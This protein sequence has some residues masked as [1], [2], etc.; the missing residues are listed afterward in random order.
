MR[1]LRPKETEQKVGLC[2]RELRHLESQGLFPKRFQLNPNGGRA[3]GHL[4]SEVDEWITGR[5]AIGRLT[6]KGFDPDRKR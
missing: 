4:E 2:D 3:V 6:R 1:V 5:A